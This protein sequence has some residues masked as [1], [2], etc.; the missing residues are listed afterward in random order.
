MAFPK[1]KLNISEERQAFFNRLFRKIFLEDWLMK[2]IALIIT[3]AL[4]LGV[5]G[6]RAP[7]TVRFRNVALNLQVPN[8]FEVTNSPVQEVNIVLTGDKRRIDQMNPRDLVVSLDLSDIQAGDRMV[9]LTPENVN[10]ELPTG[11]KIEEI[12]PDK[13]AVKLEVVEEREIP[14]KVETEGSVA[15][16]FEIYGEIILPQKV[17][18][19][20]PANYIRSLS[21]VSTEKIPL[22]N[23]QVDFTAK[24]IPLNISNSKATVLDTAVDVAFRIG[25]KRVERLYLVAIKDDI[26]NKK[27]TVVLYG[28]QSLLN[29]LRPENLQVEVTKNDTGQ[30]VP[31]LV[32]P[33]DLQGFVEI[34]K[35]KIN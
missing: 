2:L 9:Q 27:A 5:S 21:F 4:W 20:G 34:R 6:L 15:E 24:Q 11:I 14:V 33:T 12:Q 18:V 8:E 13:I 1:D 23:N 19:R 31:Q 26:S 10:I 17:R 32:L 35:L 28:G 3:L 7:T 29:N 22:D 30:D 16:N 25:E